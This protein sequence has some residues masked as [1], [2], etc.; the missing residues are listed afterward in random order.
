[1]YRDPKEEE[2]G[3]SFQRIKVR[4]FVS[5]EIKSLIFIYLPHSP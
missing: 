4:L 1:M 5:T 2:V 3:H